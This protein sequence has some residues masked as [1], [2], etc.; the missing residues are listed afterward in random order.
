MAAQGS[1]FLSHSSHDR[2]WSRKLAG[3]LARAG[4][5]VFLDEG[6]ISPGGRLIARLN[7]GLRAASGGLIVWGT[8]TR[9]SP[10]VQ[11]EYEFLLHDAIAN[12]KRLISVILATVDLP[13]LLSTR[14]SVDFRG[15]R[16]G[17]DYQD[18]LNR[19]IRAL[20]DE[21]PERSGLTGMPAG[22][23]DQEWRLEGQQ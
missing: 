5:R 7:D 16:P 15:C 11:A 13:P 4:I 20:R 6:D 22:P 3:D 1:V 23:A 8:H 14:V 17:P 18:R 2:E 21:R 19:L 12:H 10:W 9:E